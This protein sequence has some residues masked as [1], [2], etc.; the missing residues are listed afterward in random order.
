MFV[1]DCHS[2]SLYCK[3]CNCTFGE[4]GTIFKV[5]VEAPHAMLYHHGLELTESNSAVVDDD[6]NSQMQ[7]EEQ[8]FLISLPMHTHTHLFLDNFL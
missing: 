5:L 6:I 3:K 8:Q 4:K 2:C 7:M 1:G